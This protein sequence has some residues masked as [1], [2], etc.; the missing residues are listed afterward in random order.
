M[1]S[2]AA[3]VAHAFH[4]KK[5]FYPAVVMITNSNVSMLVI[6]FQGF[7]LCLLLARMF[8]RIFFGKLSDLERETLYDRSW[9]AVTET[10]LAMTIFRDEFTT[11]I[12]GL[13]GLLLAVKAFHWLVQ[14]RVDW[15]ATGQL[16]LPDFKFHVRM[17][18]ACTV[19]AAIDG[20]LIY[21]AV[22]SVQTTGPSMQLL[23]GFEYIALAVAITTSFIKY[24]LNAAETYSGEDWE[25]KSTY[26]SYLDLLSDFLKLIVYISFFLILMNF[27]GLPLHIIRDLCATF[28]SFIK[29]CNDFIQSRRAMRSLDLLPN[30][31]AE[32][33]AVDNMCIICREEMHAPIIGVPAEEPAAVPKRLPCGH[34]FHFRCCRSWL[35][36]QPNCPTC[37][38]EVLGMIG[39]ET[40]AGAAAAA[41]ARAA[42]AA[43]AA[44]PAAAA[45]PAAAAPVHA[46]AAAV[47]QYVAPANFPAHVPQFPGAAAAAAAVVPPAMPAAAAAAATP[48]AAAAAHAAPGLATPAAVP[49]AF[50][51][52]PGA[53]LTQPPPFTPPPGM[54]PMPPM[55]GMPGMPPMPGMGMGMPAGM[56]GMPGMPGMGMPGMPG[57]PGMGMPGMGMPPPSPFMNPMMASPYGGMPQQQQ[58]QQHPFAM[59]SPYANMSG[60]S[61]MASPYAASMGGGAFGG[62]GGGGMSM[63]GGQQLPAGFVPFAFNA[64]ADAPV[65]SLSDAEVRELEGAEREKVV[66]RIEFLRRYRAELDAMLGRFGQYDTVQHRVDSRTTTP[67][68]A[69][70]TA[71][72]ASGAGAGAGGADGPIGRASSAPE[73][74]SSQ[75]EEARKLRVRK[76]SE[77]KDGAEL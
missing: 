40:P 7:I 30:A 39:Q 45:V 42:A 67:A 61:G 18:S 52:S 29:R 75:R 56:P 10:C 21:H 37:R 6:Q 59:H 27:Y 70:A 36:E 9:F 12:F 54:P 2:T 63:M 64:A 26:I 4:T 69:A 13:F 25:A 19:L 55:P 72:A 3:V 14:M 62:G 44:P 8:Q 77:K 50:P 41:A 32:E 60:M 57:M 35:R 65:S 48:V 11:K 68:A 20:C 46:A 76:F 24:C 15:M 28:S 49:P 1:A 33:L 66:A 23:F 58:H 53:H 74:S 22:N 16:P 34:I 43:A 31:V 51:F 71:A 17:V 5:Q 47:P 38:T 73:Q